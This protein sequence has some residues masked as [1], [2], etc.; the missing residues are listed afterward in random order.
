MRCQ[1]VAGF[2]ERFGGLQQRLGGNAADIEA[3]AAQRRALFH[4]G[5]LQ[6]KLGCADGADIAA[7]A[8]PDDDDVECV[9]HGLFLLGS[10]GQR[11]CPWTRQR[12]S[13]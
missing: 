9:A 13:L 1:A 7:W 8:G 12:R 3:G 5:D 11:R 10:E 4:A 6:A 2:L